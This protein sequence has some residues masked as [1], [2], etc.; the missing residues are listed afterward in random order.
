MILYLFINKL[1]Y[2]KILNYMI[3]GDCHKEED[4]RY[5]WKIRND[6]DISINY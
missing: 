1:Y 3:M 5:N 4:L 2:K 6:Y